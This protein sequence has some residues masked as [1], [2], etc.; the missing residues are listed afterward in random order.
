MNLPHK[1][2]HRPGIR[3]EKTRIGG[4]TLDE[5]FKLRGRKT[6]KRPHFELQ[7]SSSNGAR[8]ERLDRLFVG[9]HEMVTNFREHLE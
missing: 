2:S 1:T 4:N 5:T 3:G 9:L 7:P 8:L 6:D